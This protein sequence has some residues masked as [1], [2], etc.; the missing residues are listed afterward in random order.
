MRGDGRGKK[1][2][3]DAWMVMVPDGAAA[4]S[5]ASGGIDVLF[6]ETKCTEN[7]GGEANEEA[8]QTVN[9]PSNRLLAGLGFV[10]QGVRDDPWP[11][12][13][14]GGTREIVEWRLDV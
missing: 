10:M 11:E 14:G 3:R 1:W 13:T 5:G 6:E 9:I 4:F 2:R 7:V 12:H 8:V